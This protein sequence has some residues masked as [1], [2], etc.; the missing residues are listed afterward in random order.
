M[1]YFFFRPKPYELKIKM[2]ETTV[3]SVGLEASITDAAQHIWDLDENRLSPNVDYVINVQGGKKPY[4]QDDKA[5]D[6]LFTSVKTSELRRPTY[7]AFIALLDN[8]TAETG[9]AESVS[10]NERKENWAFLRAIMQTAPMQFCHKY[11]VKNGK[12]V[13][14][15]PED[16][17]KLLNC[18]FSICSF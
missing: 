13:P 1:L 2:P 11:C 3:E 14:I 12:N 7:K 5:Q 16:F 9:V 10:Y 15:D 4:W 18:R 8:Y 17:I 6:P